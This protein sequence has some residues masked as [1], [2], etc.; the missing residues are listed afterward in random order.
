MAPLQIARAMLLGYP[1]ARTG[2]PVSRRT[3]PRRPRAPRRSARR[4][5]GRPTRASRARRAPPGPKTTLGMPASARIA[6][7]I[8]AAQPITGGGMPSTSAACPCTSRTMSAST[9]ISNG[10][11][12]ERRAHLG[13]QLRVGARGLGHELPHLL[14]D[15][16]GALARHRAALELDEAALGV[17]RELLPALDQRR[18][19]RPGPEQRMPLAAGKSPAEVL[20]AGQHAAGLGDR[21]DAEL[22]LRAVRGTAR[23]LDLEPG[24]ALVRDAQ[25]ELRG[26]GH[27][28]GVGAHLTRR[29]PG[30]RCSRTPRRTRPRPRR[31][32]RA[33]APRPART[34]RA[35][36]RDRPSCR[37]CRGRRGGRPRRAARAG[38]S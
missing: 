34:P 12:T 13:A 19:H 36:P 17:A 32:L 5:P 37:S 15:Q 30:C 18:V 27:D 31:R 38:R 7:S 29:R 16:L 1:A 21:V 28:G 25:L 24:E 14:L 8:Q 10:G 33:R 2:T 3:R 9:R 20:D 35:P 11:R 6:E 4:M 23:D 22:R 26:L